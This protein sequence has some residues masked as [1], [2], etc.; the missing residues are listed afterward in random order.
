[1]VLIFPQTHVAVSLQAPDGNYT[2]NNAIALLK[3]INQK[4]VFVPTRWLWDISGLQK[5]KKLARLGEPV[6]CSGAGWCS[7]LWRA[8][9]GFLKGEKGRRQRW[10]ETERK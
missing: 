1:M 6:V 5:T 7:E 4:D 10:K 8:V 9:V 3:C 2:I